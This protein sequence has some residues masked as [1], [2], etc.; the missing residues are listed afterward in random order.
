M[1]SR[2]KGEEALRQGLSGRVSCSSSGE[3]G[4]VVAGCTSCTAGVKPAAHRLPGLGAAVALWLVVAEWEL[5][6]VT[7]TR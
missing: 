1:S 3:P 7:C 6:S 4:W 5:G 2:E